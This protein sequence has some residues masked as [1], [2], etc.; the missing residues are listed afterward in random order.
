MAAKKK[1]KKPCE[2]STAQKKDRNLRRCKWQ[3][4]TICLAYVDDKAQEKGYA[5]YL[6]RIHVTEEQCKHRFM[7]IDDKLN[8]GEQQYCRCPAAFV[9]IQTAKKVKRVRKKTGEVIGYQEN[10]FGEQVDNL[11]LVI[12][13]EDKQHY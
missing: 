9:E 6:D 5:L 8:K 1:N 2:P 13:P 3:F 7:P 11:G 4:N 10:L 12:R